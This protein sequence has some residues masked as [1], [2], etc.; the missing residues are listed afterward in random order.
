MCMALAM[1]MCNTVYAHYNAPT[2]YDVPAYAHAYVLQY[3]NDTLQCLPTQ[4]D[5]V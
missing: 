5:T 4:Y 1:L 3:I 2:Y